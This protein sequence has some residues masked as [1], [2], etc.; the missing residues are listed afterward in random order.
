MSLNCEKTINQLRFPTSDKY[1]CLKF[2]DYKFDTAATGKHTSSAEMR[3]FEPLKLV[4]VKSN[5]IFGRAE[6]VYITL[7]KSTEK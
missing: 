1:G 7:K 4:G 2:G 3:N 6:L 5:V